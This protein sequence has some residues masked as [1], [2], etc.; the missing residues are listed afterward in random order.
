MWHH[1]KIE[2]PTEAFN[3]SG[4]M[5]EVTEAMLTLT[6]N[7]DIALFSRFDTPSGDMHYYFTPQARPIAELFHAAPCDKPTR[8]QVGGLTV[9][10]YALPEWLW[11]DEEAKQG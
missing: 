7:N 2:D 3:I 10:A 4:R 6:D 1:L 11:P 8:A 9:G 5:I